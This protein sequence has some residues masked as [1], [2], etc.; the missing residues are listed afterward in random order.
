MFPLSSKKSGRWSSS[1]SLG[2]KRRLQNLHRKKHP[3]FDSA[4]LRS[5][6]PLPRYI[7]NVVINPVVLSDEK[8]DSVYRNTVRRLGDGLPFNLK[9]WMCCAGRCANA[10][11]CYHT[12]I[13]Q[14]EGMMTDPEREM[15]EALDG[16]K[17]SV[18]LATW[19]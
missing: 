19:R 3:G 6:L 13:C 15:Y 11:R 9:S 12:R 7:S 2:E 4:W 16:E 17:G 1:L 14:G 5:L 10:G 8:R 18:S